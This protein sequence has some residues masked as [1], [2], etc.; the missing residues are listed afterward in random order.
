MMPTRRDELIGSG[1][2]VPNP[3][4]ETTRKLSL[5]P[6]VVNDDPHPPQRTQ[7]VKPM[8]WLQSQRVGVGVTVPAW[9]S[10]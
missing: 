2:T 3:I 6:A 5:P 9:F 1:V 10:F 7:A 4:P 8:H